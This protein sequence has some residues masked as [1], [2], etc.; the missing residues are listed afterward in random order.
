MELESRT[1]K[2]YEDEDDMGGEREV[3]ISQNHSK[4][5]YFRAHLLV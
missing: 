4:L 5:V 1:H 2:Y 3:E